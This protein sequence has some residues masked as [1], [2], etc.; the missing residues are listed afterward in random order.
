MD[1]MFSRQLSSYAICLLPLALTACGAKHAADPRTE[2]PLVR[3]A[4]VLG[5][6]AIPRSFT[7]IVG[8]RVQGDLG[9]RVSG[10]MLQRL[11]D[12]GQM[13]KRGQPLM[14]IDPIDL[15]LAAHA[16]QESVVAARA[17]AKQ[18]ADDEARNRDLVAAGAISASAYDQVKAA[19]DS[20]R[21]QLNAAEAQADVAKNASSYAVLLADADG[22]VVE[23]LAEPGQVVSAGQVVVRLAHA[24]PREAIVHLPETLRP[25]VGSEG[26][27][28]LYGSGHAAVPAKLRQLSDAADRLTRTYE[29]RY[30]LDGALAGAPLGAT[31]NIELTD[32]HASLRN[33]LQVPVGALLAPGNVPG[34][35]VLRGKPAKVTW[36]PVR[37][38][39]VS[40]D[41]ARVEG[42]IQAGDQVVSLGAQLLH[43]GE[44]VRLAAS[45]AQTA[46]VAVPG[47]QQ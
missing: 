8:A 23:T 27:A 3:V 7:G 35:W 25:A 39:S 40:D 18:A 46:S 38:L 30:V 33:D 1:L 21:A 36:R 19:A 29:A 26:K 13:V 11:V 15:G 9:F 2:A 24:G 37:V 12:T 20:A 47:G 28:T 22:V 6:P 41:M 45:N 14:R 34:V 10:K 17:R 44:Q 31:V 4:P 42:G 32:P 43:E 5:A 16:Q